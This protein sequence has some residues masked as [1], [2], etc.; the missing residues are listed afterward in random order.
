[1]KDFFCLVLLTH[2]SI[3]FSVV[4]IREKMILDGTQIFSCYILNVQ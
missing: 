1:M 3:G 4:L 2:Y